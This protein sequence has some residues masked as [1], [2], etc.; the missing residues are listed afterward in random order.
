MTESYEI[1]RQSWSR[2]L[3]TTQCQNWLIDVG[4]SMSINEIQK[5][6][7]LMQLEMDY[8]VFISELANTTD[9]EIFQFG[10]FGCWVGRA[11]EL[12]DEKTK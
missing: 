10:Q 4:V 7:N 9:L 12:L 8:H 5:Y 3:P 6:Y 11:K 2:D 1:I